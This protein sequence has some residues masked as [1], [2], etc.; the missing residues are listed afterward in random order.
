MNRY[1]L[2][3][4]VLRRPHTMRGKQCEDWVLLSTG[5]KWI[6]DRGGKALKLKRIL[7]NMTV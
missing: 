2:I 4:E 6:L 3:L 5:W 1:V 7:F